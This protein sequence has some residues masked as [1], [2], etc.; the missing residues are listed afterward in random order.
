MDICQ[1]YPSLDWSP[2]FLRSSHYFPGFSRTKDGAT[3]KFYASGLA[4]T[5]EAAI[6]CEFEKSRV[7]SL[8]ASTQTTK[9]VLLRYAAYKLTSQG[10]LVFFLNAVPHLDLKHQNLSDAKHAGAYWL[11]KYAL[12]TYLRFGKNASIRSRFQTDILTFQ[13]AIENNPENVYIFGDEAAFGTQWDSTYSQVLR[14]ALEKKLR[15][16][17][18]T[19]TPFDQLSAS[20]WRDKSTLLHLPHKV[21][22][23]AGYFGITDFLQNSRVTDIGEEQAVFKGEVSLHLK[24]ALGQFDKQAAK[25]FLLIRLETDE[26]INHLKDYIDKKHKSI[27][28]HRHMAGDKFKFEMMKDLKG[29]HIIIFK[30]LMRVGFRVPY[31]DCI[32]GVWEQATSMDTLVQG[33]IGRVTGIN[34]SNQQIHIFS[35]KNTLDCYSLYE[36]TGELKKPVYKKIGIRVGMHTGPARRIMPVQIEDITKKFKLHTKWTDERR[37]V[38]REQVRAYFHKLEPQMSVIVSFTS[39]D[40][41]VYQKMLDGV[42]ARNKRGFLKPGQGKASGNIR[43][44]KHGEIA[45]LASINIQDMKY[46]SNILL[47]PKI[48]LVYWRIEET[49]DTEFTPQVSERSVFANSKLPTSFGGEYQHRGEA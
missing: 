40:K 24:K 21:L 27:R 23:K 17:L 49:K 35:S 3:E 42:P 28:V 36:R 38:L 10:K 45:K 47:P 12:N 26:Q 7:L 4:L 15:L 8:F 29:R 34:C 32:W 48:T 33:L 11:D 13:R 18:C 44:K 9:S 43:H 22:S 37:E 41:H 5:V 14:L 1:M 20:V 6:A 16:L 39:R 30:D 2:K 25:T 31:K 19:A 46:Q